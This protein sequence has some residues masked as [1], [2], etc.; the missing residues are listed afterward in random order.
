MG[1]PLIV[2]GV[3]GRARAGKDTV[4]GVLGLHHGF[5]R[6]ALADGVRSALN[7]LSGPTGEFHKELSDEHNYR[8]AL[9]ILGTE[10]RLLIPSTKLWT[11]LALCKIAYA[12]F[13]HPVKRKRFVIPDV[14]YLAEVAHLKAVVSRWGGRFY[15]LK[16]ERPGSPFIAESSHSS[17]LEVDK[18][19]PD[20]TLWNTGTKDRLVG[21]VHDAMAALLAAEPELAPRLV[22]A[23]CGASDPDDNPF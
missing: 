5:H 8:K 20:Y 9:Q 4:A 1:E 6:V 7:D 2:I 13:G 11:S 12:A 10:A 21:H 15:L 19:E 23:G 14:R 17:E 18:I 16:V 3:T 22:P